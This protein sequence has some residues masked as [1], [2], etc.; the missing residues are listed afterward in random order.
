[1]ETGDAAV[2]A[3]W[4]LVRGNPRLLRPDAEALGVAGTDL[5]KPLQEIILGSHS[6]DAVRTVSVASGY[7]RA[8]LARL[9]QGPTR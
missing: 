6:A 1:L 4:L 2:T 7:S 5:V 3:L 8:S 9:R